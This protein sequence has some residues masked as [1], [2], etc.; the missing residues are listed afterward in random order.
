MRLQEFYT[1]SAMLSDAPI[2]TITPREFAGPSTRGSETS[3]RLLHRRRLIAAA[4]ELFSRQ[5]Y[6][7]TA[8]R[9]IA[10]EA[11]CATST[12]RREFSG[13]LGLLEEVIRACG[14]CDGVQAPRELGRPGLQEDICRLMAWEVDRMRGQR[15]CLQALLPLDSFDPVIL[16]VAGKLSLAGST[17]VLHKRLSKHGVGDAEREF[18]VCAIQAVGFALGWTGFEEADRVMFKVKQVAKVLSGGHEQV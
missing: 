18:L 5:G 12:I 10:V 13:K 1:L 7:N 8:L 6:R 9:E 14:V 16:Q 11:G 15:G 3:T 2:A 17:Q 4:A